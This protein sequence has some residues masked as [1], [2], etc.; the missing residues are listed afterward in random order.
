M[1]T[2]TVKRLASDGPFAVGA[3]YEV[4]AGDT[5]EHFQGVVMAVAPLDGKYIEVT[6]ALADAEYER[7]LDSKP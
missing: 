4:A 1:P 2:V 3:S 5:D 7:L 6:V